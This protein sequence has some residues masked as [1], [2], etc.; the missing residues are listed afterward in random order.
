MAYE[1]QLLRHMR[2]FFIACHFVSPEFGK[3]PTSQK[4]LSGP[5]G[6]YAYGGVLSEEGTF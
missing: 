5:N 2:R 3:A 1:P 6:A 4:S